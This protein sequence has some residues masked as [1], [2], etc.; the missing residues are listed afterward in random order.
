MKL[1]A[2]LCSYGPMYDQGA[3]T[4]EVIDQAASQGFGA[5]EPFPCADLDTVD[6]ARR[7]GGYAGKRAWKSVVFPPAANFW[8]RTAMRPQS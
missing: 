1:S 6:D 7:V 3:T 5:V 2:F 4:F 8:G